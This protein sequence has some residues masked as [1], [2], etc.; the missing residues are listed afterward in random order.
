[1]MLPV[2]PVK[3]TRSARLEASVAVSTSSS[4]AGAP[5]GDGARAAPFASAWRRAHLTVQE[6]VARGRTAR[7]TAPR[8]AH[9]QWKP[10]PD[11]PDPVALLEEQAQSRVQHLVPIR[12]G[13]ML[14]SPFTF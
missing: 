2:A 9:G 8:A 12:Y 4:G 6:R 5:A 3:G 13:R 14:V 11:R 1:M 7:T 10:A